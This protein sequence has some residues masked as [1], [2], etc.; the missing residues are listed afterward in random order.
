MKTLQILAKKVGWRI[1]AVGG[2]YSLEAIDPLTSDRYFECPNLEDVAHKL[3]W[4]IDRNEIKID[5]D[6]PEGE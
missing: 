2:F 1:E 5:Y 6:F 3:A 4:M